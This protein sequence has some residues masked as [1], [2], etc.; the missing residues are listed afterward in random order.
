MWT[1]RYR[2]NTDELMDLTSWT[3]FLN[4]ISSSII[5]N[6]I[7][8]STHFLREIFMPGIIAMYAS[9]LQIK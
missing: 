1:I 9:F 8:E 2:K 3:A 5:D 7:G 6:Y 4:V